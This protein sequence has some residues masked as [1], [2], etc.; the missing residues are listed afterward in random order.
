MTF[1]EQ[2]IFSYNSYNIVMLGNKHTAEIN[3][4]TAA[5][6]VSENNEVSTTSRMPKNKRALRPEHT[7]AGERKPKAPKA[8]HML[9]TKR[10]PVSP[11]VWGELSS[12][13]KAG[14][15]YDTLL[16]DMI[17]REK[18]QRLVND[19][20]RIEARGKFVEMKW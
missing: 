14:E 10:I 7:L 3:R 4:V 15:T 12:L 17:D 19:L 13:K 2:G 6:R 1:G 8:K 9:A 16:A 5:K 11:A 18:K 20:K